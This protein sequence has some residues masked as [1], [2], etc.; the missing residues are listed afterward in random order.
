MGAILIEV[1]LR[2]PR[3][4]CAAEFQVEEEIAFISQTNTSVVLFLGLSWLFVYL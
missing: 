2:L 3:E 4:A 1:Y